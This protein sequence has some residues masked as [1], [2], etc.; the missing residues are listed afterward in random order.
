[1]GLVYKITV[2]HKDY[3]VLLYVQLDCDAAHAGG[4]HA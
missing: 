4:E 2:H 1:M 3:C